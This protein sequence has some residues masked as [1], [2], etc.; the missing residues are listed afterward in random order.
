[1]VGHPSPQPPPL[2]GEGVQEKNWGVPPSARERTRGEYSDPIGVGGLGVSPRAS[3]LPPPLSRG[4]GQGEGF[5]QMEAELAETIV[6]VAEQAT[7]LQVRVGVADGKF[8]A[9][10][11]AMLAD[12]HYPRGSEG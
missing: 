2:E 10:V 11:A 8:A 4:G 9:Y 12:A 5:D 1:M 7:G 3:T 6:A